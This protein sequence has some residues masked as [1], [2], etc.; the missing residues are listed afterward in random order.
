MLC[1]IVLSSIIPNVFRSNG[2]LAREQDRAK[3]SNYLFADKNDFLI[4]IKD[5]LFLGAPLAQS[6]SGV[7]Q[8]LCG[9]CFVFFVSLTSVQNAVFKI[10][11]NSAVILSSKSQL[12][13]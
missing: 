3:K 1:L 8:Q 7:L 4:I 13:I 10:K 6:S 12:R 9:L 5:L 11:A 2:I